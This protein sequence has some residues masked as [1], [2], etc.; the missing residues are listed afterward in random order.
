MYVKLHLQIYFLTAT[1]VHTIQTSIKMA[2]YFGLL[3]HT[4][5]KISNIKETINDKIGARLILIF[6]NY[7]F[8]FP[9]C[10]IVTYAFIRRLIHT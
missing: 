1:V 8:K 4:W 9:P 2:V 7:N 6:F 5:A 10:I 3:N